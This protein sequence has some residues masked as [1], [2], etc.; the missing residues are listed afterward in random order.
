MGVCCRLS[1]FSTANSLGIDP[2]PNIALDGD[3]LKK[4]IQ[5]SASRSISPRGV[6]QVKVTRPKFGAGMEGIEKLEYD[7]V[8]VFVIDAH[9]YLVG[10]STR[11]RPHANARG[12]TEDS[13]RGKTIP[14]CDLGKPMQAIRIAKISM[15]M[16]SWIGW[17][18]LPT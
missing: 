5:P 6:S 17:R 16:P 7:T 12:K 9:Q 4:G 3:D 18:G 11:P 1:P 10:K 8:V 14:R 15:R 13:S 2:Q